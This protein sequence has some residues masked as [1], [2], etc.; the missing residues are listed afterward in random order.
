ML[1]DGTDRGRRAMAVDV[2]ATRRRFTRKEFHRMAEAGILREDDRV[3][4][5]RGEIVEMSP[6]G[7]RHSAFVDN[8]TRLLVRRLP[9]DAIVRVKGPI[10]LADDTE[11][12]PDLTVLRRRAVPYK[13]REAWA[14]DAMLIIEVAESSLAFD[15]ST[16]QRL[17]AEVG[18]PEYWVVDC[19]AEAVEVHRAPGPE[20]YRDVRLVTRQAA[21]SPQAFSDVA[22]TIADIFV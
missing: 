18:I 19:S 11:P 5:I 21:L 16:K 7:P 6:I 4:L 10:A 15:R 14:E 8:L 2:A 20:G 1:V 9:D 17:Y 3:E 22:L 13:D 12:Q